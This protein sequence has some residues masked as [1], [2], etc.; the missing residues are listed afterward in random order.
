M[1]HQEYY[2]TLFQFPLK[3]TLPHGYVGVATVF[4]ELFFLHGPSIQ[5]THAYV[6]YWVHSCLREA[7]RTTIPETPMERKRNLFSI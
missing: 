6:V 2:I 7:F 1:L 5:I 4:Y 3:V